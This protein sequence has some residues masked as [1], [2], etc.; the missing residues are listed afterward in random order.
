MKEEKGVTGCTTIC[1]V[2][3][4]GD[5]VSPVLDVAGTAAGIFL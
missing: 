4:L 3:C 5:A 2:S 1:I